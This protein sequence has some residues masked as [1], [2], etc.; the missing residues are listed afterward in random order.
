[1]SSNPSVSYTGIR[2]QTAF[3]TNISEQNGKQK[4]RQITGIKSIVHIVRSTEHIDFVGV[5][6][7]R[8]WWSLGAPISRLE[9]HASF[10]LGIYSSEHHFNRCHQRPASQH[11]TSYSR[12][13]RLEL[14]VYHDRPTVPSCRANSPHTCILPSTD[15]LASANKELQAI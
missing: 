10:A 14:R 8:G 4:S 5:F 11:R 7:D 6:L 1:M 12:Y 9:S 15:R 13:P 3:A 2:D